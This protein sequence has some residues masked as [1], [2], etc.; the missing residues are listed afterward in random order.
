MTIR[1]AVE[2]VLISSQLTAEKNGGIFILEMGES[3]SIKELAKRMITLS[4]KT[5]AEIKIEVTGLR[6]GEKIAEKL[7]FT[8]EEMNKTEVDGIL[9]TKNKLYNVDFT[10]YG[11]LVSLIMKNNMIEAMK[12]FREIL[13]EF[14]TN[15]ENKN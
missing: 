10:D 5:E 11:K 1:E 14:K 13:P 6:K 7:N 15:E 8:N 4:G 3:V 2:L 9:F 12:K